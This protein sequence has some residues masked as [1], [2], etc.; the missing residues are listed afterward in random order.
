MP[1]VKSIIDALQTLEVEVGKESEEN[2]ENEYY[3]YVG[4]TDTDFK[5]TVLDKTVGKV[6]TFEVFIASSPS[7][8]VVQN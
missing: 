6:S 3:V 1:N 2:K 8:N 5:A 4:L 7:F